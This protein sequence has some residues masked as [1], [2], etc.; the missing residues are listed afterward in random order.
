MLNIYF[1]CLW[2]I[3]IFSSGNCLNGFSSPANT[4]L[5]SRKQHRRQAAP[6]GC[7]GASA[8]VLK[9]DCSTSFSYSLSSSCFDYFLSSHL[10]P[11]AMSPSSLRPPP[12]ML[13]HWA[14]V[15]AK[16][17]ILET[18][19]RMWPKLVLSE[20]EWLWQNP[21]R[22]PLTKVPPYQLICSHGRGSG[23]TLSL[24]VSDEEHSLLLWL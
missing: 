18:K 8:F 11:Q 1:M 24:R 21:S 20:T 16:S 2:V 15:M 23:H 6:L 4:K 3:C 10:P 14:P 19:G 5:L 22:V 9:Y 12:S 13:L 17:E 7:Q